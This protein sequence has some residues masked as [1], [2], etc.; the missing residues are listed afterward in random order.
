MLDVK[1]NPGYE[2]LGMKTVNNP[3]YEQQGNRLAANAAYEEQ[4]ADGSYQDMSD[5][6]V[7]TTGYMD[8]SGKGNDGGYLSVCLYWCSGS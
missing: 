2:E 1:A 8:M 3:A 5:A 7:P 4:K 6:N